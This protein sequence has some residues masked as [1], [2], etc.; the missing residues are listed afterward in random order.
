MK[1]I[2]SALV[3][4]MLMVGLVATP[5]L[6]KA[7]KVDLHPSAANHV[8]W[9]EAAAIFNNSSGPNNLEVT[10]QIKGATPDFTYGVFLFVDGAWY[11]GAPVGNVTT[12][13][14][15]NATFHVNV[16]VAPGDHLV[17]V[18]VATPLPAGLDQYLAWPGIHMTFK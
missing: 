11:K 10:V 17:T 13:G 12:N 1:R 14:V 5:T 6:A 9:G 3:L 15:G 7:E 4:G 2:A 8:T 16:A 18:D